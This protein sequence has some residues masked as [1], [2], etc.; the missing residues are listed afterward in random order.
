MIELELPDTN[1]VGRIADWIELQ[2]LY[3]GKQI[4][5]NKILSIIEN[6]TGDADENKIDSAIQE[7]IRRLSLY[8]V[9][10]PY[11]IKNNIVTPIFKWDRYPELALCLYFSAYGAADADNG[12]KL[13]E[14][15]TRN[16]LSHFLKSD[17]IIFGF[18]AGI[19]FKSQIDSLAVAC[20]EGRGDNP[21]PFDKDRGADVVLWK[22]FGDNRNSQIYLLVQ[23][24]AGGKWREKKPIPLASWRRYIHW[25]PLTTI[26]AIAITQIVDS[27][28]WTNAVDDYG[29]VIDRARLFSIINSSGYRVDNS[30]RA[31]ILQWCKS[32]FN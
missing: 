18:P 21:T 28:K 10:K 32:R 9:V 20:N 5:K 26:P 8:G 16:C 23:C 1:N 11:S 25:H 17:S 7:L 2:A 27:E 29:V 24:A 15:L 4:S 19:S 3:T 6:D 31:D 13:F 22:T 30:L 14:S 12:T